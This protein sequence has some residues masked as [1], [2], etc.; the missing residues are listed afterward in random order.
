MVVVA[1]LMSANDRAYGFVVLDAGREVARVLV[2]DTTDPT[3][4]P[5]AEA[6]AERIAELFRQPR[7]LHRAAAAPL[8]RPDRLQLA[9]TLLH[10]RPHPER[11][12]DRHRRARHAAV[13]GPLQDHLGVPLPA[14]KPAPVSAA[15]APAAESPASDR[16]GHPHTARPSSLQRGARSIAAPSLHSDSVS[17]RPKAVKVAP[18]PTPPP[19]DTTFP[20]PP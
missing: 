17:F 7:A 5:G 9:A 19:P 16:P 4:L 8:Q 15:P 6:D 12:L 1:K 11:L 2:G 10:R 20:S 3:L 14:T 18:R 13:P